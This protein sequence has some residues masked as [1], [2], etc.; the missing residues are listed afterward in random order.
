M[1]KLLPLALTALILTGCGNG[2]NLTGAKARTGATSAQSIAG[3][4]KG[5][6]NYFEAAFKAADTDESNSLSLAEIPLAMPAVPGQATQTGADPAAQRLDL[7]KRLDLNA[8]GKVTYREFARPEFVNQSITIFRLVAGQAFVKMDVNGDRTL[9]PAEL[10]VTDG[11]Q[12][13]F[14]AY[15]KNSNGKLT[16]SEFEDGYAASLTATPEPVDPAPAPVTP[17]DPASDEP[18]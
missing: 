14:D 13:D 6:R 16:L 9:I 18:A 15:D 2:M 3:V 7:M 8:D 5:V 1:T 4:N 12:Y 11:A 10:V 17:A